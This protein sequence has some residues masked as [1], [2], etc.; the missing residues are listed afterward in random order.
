MNYCAQWRAK[1]SNFSLEKRP[2]D[3]RL[4]ISDKQGKHTHVRLKR[5]QTILFSL[6]YTSITHVDFYFSVTLPHKL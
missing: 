6:A 5:L 3:E 2:W 1:K 4:A